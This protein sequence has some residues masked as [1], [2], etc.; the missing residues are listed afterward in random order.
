MHKLLRA[1]LPDP[2]TLAESWSD[3]VSVAEPLW[4]VVGGA[5]MLPLALVFPG[6][7]PVAPLLL[8]SFLF[9]RVRYESRR[10]QAALV[11]APLCLTTASFFESLRALH[12]AADHIGMVMPVPL[13]AIAVAFILLGRQTRSPYPP[14]RAGLLVVSVFLP[15]VGTLVA[16]AVLFVAFRWS[17]TDPAWRLNTAWSASAVA[18]I[19]LAWWMSRTHRDALAQLGDARHWVEHPLG[20]RVPC[21]DAAGARQP[22]RDLMQLD[23]RCTLDG[24]RAAVQEVNGRRVAAPL[25]VLLITGTPVVAASL[26]MMQRERTTTTDTSSLPFLG[27]RAE[28]RS[29]SGKPGAL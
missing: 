21:V 15:L 9:V 27:C 1:W 19:G 6:L 18:G 24:L 20:V 13:A 29:A 10:E 22:Y 3:P 23:V 7:L 8:V 2:V 16:A 4:M 5:G 28:P 12:V 26:R 25:V 17:S 14:G 11:V